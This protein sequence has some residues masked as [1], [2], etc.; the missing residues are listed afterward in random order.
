MAHAERVVVVPFND[1][2]SSVQYRPDTAKVVLLE[3]HHLRAPY[4]TVAKM[5]FWCL[6]SAGLH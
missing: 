2:P 1:R 3:E 6:R 5:G 4:D